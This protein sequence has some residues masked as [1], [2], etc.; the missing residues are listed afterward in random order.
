MSPLEAILQEI[1][2]TVDAGLYYAAI[3]VTLAI[4]EICARMEQEDRTQGRSLE[5]YS[6]WFDTHLGNKY[7]RLTGNDCYYLR[8]GVAHHAAFSHRQFGY[9]RVVFSLPESNGNIFH[10]NIMGDAL[11]LDAVIFCSDMIE[12]ARAWLVQKAD[13]TTVQRHLADL[14]TVRYDGMAPYFKGVPVIA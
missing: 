11:N 13:D 10:N 5:L 2:K 14:V 8:C 1:E 4:P 12:A 3:T 6:V 9:T 7:P